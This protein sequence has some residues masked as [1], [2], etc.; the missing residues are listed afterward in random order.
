MMPCNNY[1]GSGFVAALRRSPG[2]RDNG[3]RPVL[4]TN[5]FRLRGDN[6][7]DVKCKDFV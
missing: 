3:R 6:G 4:P 7:R 2:V 1:G 5:E